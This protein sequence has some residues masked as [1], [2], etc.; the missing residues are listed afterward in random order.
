MSRAGGGPQAA[1]DGVDPGAE[2]GGEPEEPQAAAAGDGVAPA[3][4]HVE[5]PQI[6]MEMPQAQALFN[7]AALLAAAG[8]DGMM[9][10]A[11]DGGLDAAAQ[12]PADPFAGASPPGFPE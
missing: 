4:E 1:G 5:P 9:H 3:A 11:G 8:I 7:Y 6:P 12:G 10:E 2:G